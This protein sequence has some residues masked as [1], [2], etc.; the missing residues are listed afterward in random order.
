M[1]KFSSVNTYNISLVRLEDT[2][3]EPCFSDFQAII[4]ACR[5]WTTINSPLQVVPSQCTP[6]ALLKCTPSALLKCTP[7]ALLKCTPS[8]L[9]KCTPQVHSQRTPELIYIFA[10]ALP[11]HSGLYKW[12]L[13]QCTPYALHALQAHSYQHMI[14]A[15]T[16]HSRAARGAIVKF[17]ED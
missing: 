16:M 6:S 2:Y 7:S 8:A 12:Y 9:L 14:H 3:H 17:N 5:T 15:L 13:T 11:T 1:W 4:R 10:P